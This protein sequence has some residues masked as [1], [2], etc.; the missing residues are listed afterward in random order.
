MESISATEPRYFWPLLLM[1][2]EIQ[3]SCNDY[4]TCIKI[5][6]FFLFLFLNALASIAGCLFFFFI[7]SI[8]RYYIN[9]AKIFF[10]PYKTGIKHRILV[11]SGL[12]VPPGALIFNNTYPKALLK[13]SSWNY[14]TQGVL[15]TNEDLLR[16]SVA[17]LQLL[18]CT[19]TRKEVVISLFSF[20]LKWQTNKEEDG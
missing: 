17:P 12:I 2:Q 5:A 18:R 7:H 15:W 8:N 1:M 19:N 20:N 3:S 11:V 16:S 13:S 6:I 4:A 10:F 9:I 14:F